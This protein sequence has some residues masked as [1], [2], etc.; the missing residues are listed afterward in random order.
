MRST[1]Q[2]KY[3]RRRYFF[4]MG[5]CLFAS[6]AGSE[7]VHRLYSPDLSVEVPPFDPAW[8]RAKIEQEKKERD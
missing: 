1:P 3:W 7:F 5:F 2:A 8:K 4:L 6:F